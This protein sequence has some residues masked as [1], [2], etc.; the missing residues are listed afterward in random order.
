MVQR[1]WPSANAAVNTSSSCCAATFAAL[2]LSATASGVD[3]ALEFKRETDRS[4]QSASSAC[5]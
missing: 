3:E 2:S 4:P 1:T 5:L